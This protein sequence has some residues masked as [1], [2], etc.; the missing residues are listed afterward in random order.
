VE[1][2]VYSE[3][4]M[5]SLGEA[6]S[7]V[8]APGDLI[9]IIGELGAGKTTLTRGIARGLGYSGRVTSPTFTLMNM[10]PADPEI[11]HFDFYRLQE[12]ELTDLGLNDYLERD[13]VS[14][15]EWPQTGTGVLPG[16]AL[17]IKI[18]LCDDDYERERLVS[19]SACGLRYERKLEELRQYAGISH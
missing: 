7:K 10:Y 18:E 9:Y 16:E 17:F 12:E 1:I 14:I 6:I 5:E 13:A 11:C 3:G 15:V 19:V 2:K 8:I 4:E